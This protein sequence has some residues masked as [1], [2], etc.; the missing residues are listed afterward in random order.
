MN[1]ICQLLILN[2]IIMALTTA[3][4]NIEIRANIINYMVLDKRQ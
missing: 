2:N 1:L 3:T 4:E